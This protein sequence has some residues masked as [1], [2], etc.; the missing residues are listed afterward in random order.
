MDFFYL[1]RLSRETGT[2]KQADQPSSSW[3][4]R[5]PT[6]VSEISHGNADKKL[7]SASNHQLAMPTQ[8]ATATSPAYPK[9]IK[10]K[11]S[12][13]IITWLQKKLG[14]G[15]RNNR[16]ALSDVEQRGR[17]TSLK[18]TR[19]PRF[20]SHVVKGQENRNEIDLT[21]STHRS[22][23]RRS[24]PS[25]FSTWAPSNT[26]EA[27]EDASIR[28]LAPSPLP[29]S[30]PPS[31]VPSRS[32]SS[33]LSY[34]RT[35][36]SMGG[37]STRPTTLSIDV[38]ANGMAHIAEAPPTPTSI[39]YSPSPSPVLGRF[40]SSRTSHSM[41]TSITFSA[42]PPNSSRPPSLNPGRS[43]ALQAP[44][45]TAHHPRN[46]PRPSSPPNDNA[47]VLTLASSAYALVGSAGRFGNWNSD[48]Q[49]QLGV[50]SASHF[51]SDDGQ[52]EYE[53]RDFDASVRALRPRSSRRGSWESE[54]SG[55]SARVAREKSVRTATS[56][57][58]GT[59]QTADLTA[60]EMDPDEDPPNEDV[61]SVM[62][63]A[64]DAG[65][66]DMRAERTM[67]GPELANELEKDT[68]AL[69]GLE[70]PQAQTFAISAPLASV[71]TDISGMVIPEESADPATLLPASPRTLTH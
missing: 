27:D 14:G 54:G 56:G 62:Y 65:T 49:S 7:P 61:T 38:G 66:D 60:T 8:V 44:L 46:N 24:T 58:T 48:S 30:S 5:P 11:T 51:L 15:G 68:T 67:T 43:G 42:L 2:H 69:P 57:R 40:P 59:L 1:S 64:S 17:S 47:S 32:S 55:W 70:T 34:P 4:P 35:F 16:R 6:R 13:P 50:D 36:Q 71:D 21:P 52:M 12:K 26:L 29:P 18:E 23:S 63:P 28:P 20:E 10:R 45:H 22:L 41:S 19:P 31:P 25:A 39:G 9:V 53:G 3:H 37:A 33:Y